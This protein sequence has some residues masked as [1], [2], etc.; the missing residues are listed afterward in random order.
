MVV[1]YLLITLL[2][3]VKANNQTIVNVYRSCHKTV[4][5]IL[6]SKEAFIPSSSQLPKWCLA[7]RHDVA[8]CIA[9]EVMYLSHV[10]LNYSES[11]DR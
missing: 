6:D 1:V 7:M 4:D 11:N 2:T 9:S 10:N 8:S 5:D 3:L